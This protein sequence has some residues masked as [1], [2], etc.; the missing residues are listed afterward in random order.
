M[1]IFDRYVLRQFLPALALALI[2]FISIFLVV[3]FIEKLHR[4]LDHQ[5]AAWAVARYF[6][7]KAPYVIVMMMPVAI[8]MATFLTLGQMS[9]LNELVAIVTSGQSL[10]RL[11]LPVLAVAALASAAS[12]VLGEVVVPQ[13]TERREQ[14]LDEEID[15]LPPPPLDERTDVTL[16]GLDGV[17]YVARRYRIP[18]RRLHDLAI[19]RYVDGRLT[20]RIDARVAEWSGS[21]WTLRQGTERTFSPDGAER[22]RNFDRMRFVAAEGPEEFGSPPEDPDKLGWFDLRRYV[23]RAR[24]RGAPLER[25]VVDL[26]VKLAFP[27][28]N[29][30]VGIIGCALAMQLRQPSP[31]LGFG[32]SVSIAFFYFGVMRLCETLGDGGVLPPVVAGWAPS[33]LFGAWAGLLLVQLHRR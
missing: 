30:I 8:L 9:R 11:S 28:A 1:T 12:F 19:Y 4:F 14:I 23:E 24:A 25:Y 26:H 15:R 13:A 16:R 5:A 20:R 2:A 3:D 7:W 32:L 18:E 27:L 33:L 29:L 31:A 10:A 17:V 6:L 22:S 21:S